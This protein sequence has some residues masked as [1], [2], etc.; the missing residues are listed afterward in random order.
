MSEKPGRF[1]YYWTAALAERDTGWSCPE[2]PERIKVLSP[3]RIVDEKVGVAHFAVQPKEA[4]ILSLAHDDCYVTAVEEA[5]DSRRRY[6]DSGD[7]MVTS[8]VFTQALL[9]AS[10]GCAAM[11]DICTGKI[12]RAFCAVRPPGHHANRVRA[13]GFC[14]FNNVAIAAKYAQ[15]NYGVGRVLIVDWDVHPGNGTQEIFW[16]DPAVFTLSFHQADLFPETGRIDLRGGGAGAGFNRNVP[17]PPGTDAA[18]YLQTF[19][20][21][22][23]KTTRGFRPELV[24]ISAGFDAHRHDP[25]SNLLLEQRHFAEMTDIVLRHTKG[26]TG[27][28]ILSVL[29]GGYNPIGLVNCVTTHLSTLFR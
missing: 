5:H 23:E 8:D 20:A 2:N 25:A 13:L 28:R 18:T 1:G 24:L 15:A 16:E 11:D 14:V 12:L 3:D 27:G 10:A 4:S 29:E 9:A 17:F 19:E 6:L 21:I 26:A 22:L 7:T